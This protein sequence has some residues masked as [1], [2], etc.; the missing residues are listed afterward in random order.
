MIKLFVSDMDGTLLNADHVISPTNAQAIRQ[1]QAAGIEFMIATGRDYYSAHKLLAAHGL[2][3]KM[4]I[5]NGAGFVDEKGQISVPHPLDAKVTQD[6][7][8]YLQLHQIDHT[9][10]TDQGLFVPDCQRFKERMRAFFINITQQASHPELQSESDVTDAQL[11]MHLEQ[12]K[13]LA[14]LKLDENTLALKF[15]V[16]SDQPQALEAFHQSFVDH[17]LLDI[18]SSNHDNLE[19][20]SK[21][22]QKGI[23]IQDYVTQVGFDMIQVLTIGDSLNDRSMLSMAGYSYAMENAPDAVKQLAKYQAP[24]HN[25]DG[26]ATIINR[27]LSNQLP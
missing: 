20:T 19:V 5:L 6:I 16:M 8:H 12:V 9:L 7:L 18:T 15:M 25:E 23:A 4:I 1:L 10:I 21:F 3:C 27:V 17:P 11:M 14:D 22:A 13:P 26:V 2:T 24:H